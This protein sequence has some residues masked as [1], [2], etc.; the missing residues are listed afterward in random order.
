M[1]EWYFNKDIYN[2]FLSA[3]VKTYDVREKERERERERK[4]ER[5]REEK[6]RKTEGE[7]KRV[8]D[9]ERLIEMMLTTLVMLIQEAYKPRDINDCMLF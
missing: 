7:W 2:S 3:I 8:R 1:N 6:E 5:E 9:K 4:K